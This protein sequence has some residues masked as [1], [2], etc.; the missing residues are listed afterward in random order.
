MNFYNRKKISQLL[1]IYNS[2]LQSVNQVK[3]LGTFMDC[4]LSWK[5]HVGY[6]RKKINKGFYTILQLKKSLDLK[7]IFCVCY[8]L[9]D[10][11]VSNNIIFW[12]SIYRSKKSNQIFI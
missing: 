9:I 11:L 10:P 3:F 5:A 2:Y 12:E 6:D 1:N 4:D 7:S 8:A